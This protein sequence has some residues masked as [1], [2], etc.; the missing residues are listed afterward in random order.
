MYKNKKSG[1]TLLE[2]LIVVAIM[3]I[4]SVVMIIIL[5]PAETLKKSR[6]SQRMSDLNT[7]KTAIGIYMTAATSTDM[8]A[9]QTV[10]STGATTAKISYSLTT[11]TGCTTVL[12]T[13]GT[14][15]S[16]TAYNST[17]C[18]APSATALNKVDGTGWVPI[19]FNSLTGG[20]PISSLPIDP[21]NSLVDGIV[22]HPTTTDLVYRYAC[23]NSNGGVS[24][25]PGK[26]FEFDARLESAAYGPGGSDDK[27]AKDGGDN[28]ALYEVGS[29][30]LLM[31]T[32][33]T[34][35]GAGAGF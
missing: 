8:D 32:G 21:T 11:I 14:D 34:G 6:D 22:G 29:S 16:D 10:C 12:P 26:A 24:T 3:A 17:W 30:V 28:N 19:A 4:L 13:L 20:S 15:S 35:G 9:S 18:I 7:L 27:S 33:G 5:D 25:K 1:F 23:Q 31:G 2:L